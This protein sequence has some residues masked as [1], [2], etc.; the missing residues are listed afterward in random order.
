M[1]MNA[2]YLVLEIFV[3]VFAGLFLGG[4]GGASKQ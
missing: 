2:E 4:R 1:N 3:H